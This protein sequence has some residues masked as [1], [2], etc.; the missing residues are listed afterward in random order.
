M[1][2]DDGGYLYSFI[3]H[4]LAPGAGFMDVDQW[5]RGNSAFVGDACVNIV[6]FI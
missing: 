2:H 5:G 1:I 6:R 3:T 4:Y